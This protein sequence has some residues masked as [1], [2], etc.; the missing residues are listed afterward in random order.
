M[1]VRVNTE[2]GLEQEDEVGI[3]VETGKIGIR[4]RGEDLREGMRGS[5]H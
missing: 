2:A 4:G 1:G 3:K 5:E